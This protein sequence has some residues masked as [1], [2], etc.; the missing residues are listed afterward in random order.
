MR[1]RVALV[2]LASA[3]IGQFAA[4]PLPAQPADT[5][6]LSLR[7]AMGLA[8]QGGDEVRIAQA[9]ADIADAQVTLAR[10]GALPQ[11]RLNAGYTRVLESA[12]GQAV[13][14][15]FNQPNTYSS[16][17]TVSYPLFQGGR[18]IGGIRAASRLR[19]AARYG[20][21]EVRQQVA[22][23]VERAYLQT[24]FTIQLAEIHAANYGLA[25]ARL[26]QTERLQQAGR[27]SRYD[28]LRRRVERANLEP[29]LT[30]ARADRDLAAL[31]LKRLLRLPAYR[32][33][34]LTTT[35]GPDEIRALLADVST[36]SGDAA[37][38]PS[39]RSAEMTAR[40]RRDAIGVARG[41]LLPTI[42]TFV[43]FG[44]QAFPRAGFPTTSGRLDIE[45]CPSATPSTRLCQNG[46]WFSDRIWGIT[47]SWSLFDGF[48]TQG[49]IQLAR[50]QAR[51]AEAELSRV[52]E[53]AAIEVSRA[54]ATLS[55]ARSQYEARSQ[56]STEASEVFQ[57]ASLRFARGL[58]T[59]LDV[60]DAQIALLS[61]RTNEARAT[62]DVYLAAAGLARARGR[63]VVPPQDPI[64][65]SSPRLPK[66]ESSDN[67]Q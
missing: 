42:S 33:I 45:S 24:L 32:P 63:L 14:S 34:R 9:Q 7:D 59:Q 13:G 47:A 43:Q 66:V 11:L 31:D 23:D 8:L 2:A 35:I 5:L 22:L 26:T 18:I 37:T 53:A 60:S 10:S 46:G 64:L 38:R 48:R 50:A 29:S 25:D 55:R 40:A 16:N 12:R 27:A 61:A 49:A 36:D 62:F 3:G 19:D 39:V 44:Y 30:Q 58:S 28:V 51:A 52:Q 15:F 6:S 17:A 54:I 65:P 56:T 4:R 1:H 21:Q 57:L 41:E 67:P 20:E